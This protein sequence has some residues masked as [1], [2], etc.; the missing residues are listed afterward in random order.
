ML[1]SECTHP[2]IALSPYGT[3]ITGNALGAKSRLGKA[4]LT[5][6]IP[7][8]SPLS[9]KVLAMPPFCA[10]GDTRQAPP[11]LLQAMSERDKTKDFSLWYCSGFRPFIPFTPVTTLDSFGLRGPRPF[12]NCQDLFL[13]RLYG[14]LDRAGLSDNTY[15]VVV[16]DHGEVKKRFP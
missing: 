8:S 4:V 2:L 3:G 13:E 5:R 16:G 12:C 14:Q 11:C 6:Q 10:L 7:R 9:G 1:L 15:V